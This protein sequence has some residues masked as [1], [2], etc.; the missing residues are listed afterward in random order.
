M[1]S[2]S[3]TFRSRPRRGIKKLKFIKI[4]VTNRGQVRCKVQCHAY[5]KM[6]QMNIP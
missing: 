3:H 5:N 6:D 1:P 2:S 4:L